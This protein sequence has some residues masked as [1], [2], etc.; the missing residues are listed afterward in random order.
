MLV[1][2]IKGHPIGKETRLYPCGP[3]PLDDT[4]AFKAAFVILMNMTLK[5]KG[6]LL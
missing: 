1:H 5:V 4:I 6:R 2:M 3:Q